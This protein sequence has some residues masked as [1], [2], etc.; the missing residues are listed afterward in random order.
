M[1]LPFRR[2]HLC[3]AQL[4][5]RL[6]DHGRMSEQPERV[7]GQDL[8]AAVR[9]GYALHEDQVRGGLQVRTGTRPDNAQAPS[10][11]AH[12][13]LHLHRAAPEERLQISVQRTARVRDRG[14]RTA[15]VHE[16]SEGQAA[17]WPPVFGAH[18]DGPGTDRFRRRAAQVSFRTVREKRSTGR[19]V[20]ANQNVRKQVHDRDRATTGATA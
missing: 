11:A 3:A 14:C 20:Q 17:G 12:P 8:S 4:G 9:R 19:R 7:Q 2:V 13:R 16:C 15:D 6:E 10:D 5:E 18:P 1:E